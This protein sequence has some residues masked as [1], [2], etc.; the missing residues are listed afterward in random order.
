LPS[1]SED[2]FEFLDIQ[3]NNLL[4]KFEDHILHLENKIKK[5]DEEYKKQKEK[6]KKLTEES[7]R[8][9]KAM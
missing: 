5:Q 6:L 4:K 1:V 3:M 9:H 7:K 2:D 8:K